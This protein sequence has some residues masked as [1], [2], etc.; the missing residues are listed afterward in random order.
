MRFTDS[1]IN[2]KIFLK[3]TRQAFSPEVTSVDKAAKQAEAVAKI[4]EYAKSRSG[5]A[6]GHQKFDILDGFLHKSY[7]DN[8]MKERRHKYLRKI[9]YYLS[10]I[11]ENDD[12]Y[13]TSIR[14]IE[15]PYTRQI[16]LLNIFYDEQDRFKVEVITYSKNHYDSVE[17][18]FDYNFAAYIIE[19][20]TYFSSY[21]KVISFIDS[22]TEMQNKLE[23]GKK[24]QVIKK[25]RINLLKEKTI[26]AKI[27]EI[28]NEKKLVYRT[29]SKKNHMLLIIKLS[30]SKT[31]EIKIRF[32]K[33]QTTLQKL[34]SLID[35]LIELHEQGIE[36]R[37]K[38]SQNIISGWIY[39]PGSKEK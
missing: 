26:A 33:F 1:L 3:I 30:R 17:S 15:S 18:E 38:N 39:P 29:E 23:E 5:R 4:K 19:S 12:L 16:L 21:E 25:N 27:K 7:S 9:Y 6:Y 24:Q 28:V 22:V 2:R 20:M 13:R 31:I 11:N 37:H 35:S 36:V 34:S 10:I 14:I 32:S 8:F